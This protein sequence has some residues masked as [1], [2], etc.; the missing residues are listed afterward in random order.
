MPRGN[1]ET[2]QPRSLTVLLL[3]RLLDDVNFNAAFVL[4]RKQRINLNLLVDHDINQ[5]MRNIDQF[6]RQVSVSG[7]FLFNRKGPIKVKEKLMKLDFVR[8]YL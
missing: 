1:L 2:I 5:F 8:E 4:A 3:R 7:I 6:V